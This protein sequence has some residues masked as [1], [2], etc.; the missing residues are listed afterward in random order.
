M[1]L[2]PRAVAVIGDG[3]R[4]HVVASGD[5][6]L[7]SAPVHRRRLTAVGDA[8][9]P[10]VTVDLRAVTFADSSALHVLLDARD[11]ITGRGGTLR[12][13]VA[14]GP[15]ARLLDVTGVG[16]LLTVVVPEAA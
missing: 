8:G 1:S 2:P 15:V 6:D 13:I 3:Q 10:E 14:P 7:A 9:W 12:V 11:R 5:L 4:V 16:T